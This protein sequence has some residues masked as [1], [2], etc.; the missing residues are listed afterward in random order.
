[1]RELEYLLPT[2]DPP[3]GGLARLRRSVRSRSRHGRPSRRSWAWVVAACVT[4]AVL[5]V[6]SPRWIAQRQQTAAFAAASLQDLSPHLPA[7][8]IVVAHGAALQLPS[9][10]PNVRLYLV[11]SAGF[12][13]NEQPLAPGHAAGAPR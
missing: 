12:R 1:M 10:Q 4:A 7:D 6:L 5:A 11:Q 13:A 9:G 8:S 2:L 3:A